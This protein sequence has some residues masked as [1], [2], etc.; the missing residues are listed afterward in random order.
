MEGFYFAISIAG[1]NGPNAR[2]KVDNDY[3]IYNDKGWTE[4]IRTLLKIMHCISC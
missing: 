1:L 4:S 3:D 2:K